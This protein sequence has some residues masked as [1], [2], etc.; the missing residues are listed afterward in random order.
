MLHIHVQLGLPS[1]VQKRNYNF[2]EDQQLSEFIQ[3]ISDRMNYNDQTISSFP[4][5]TCTGVV[6]FRDRIVGI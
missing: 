5:H 4:L 1:H 2:P 3:K 6:L